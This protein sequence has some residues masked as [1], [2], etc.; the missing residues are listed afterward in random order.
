MTRAETKERNRRALL[1]AALVVIT[2]DGI[3][4]RLDDIAAQAE[5]TTGAVYSLFG[6]KNALVLA[7]VADS[8][9]PHYS[10]IEQS[11]PPGSELLEAV[12][13]IARDYRRS[14][15]APDAVAAMS[16]QIA[17][18]DMSLHDQELGAQLAESVRAQESVLVGLLTGRRH[19]GKAVTAQ[20][21][22]RLATALRALFVGL[23]QGVVLGI[24][25]DIDEQY[26]TDAARALGE[27]LIR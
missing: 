10:A 6:S 7:L 14:C 22:V 1:N 3:R 13:A 24:T 4:A 5:L 16:L 17:L 19:R 18:L 23:S 15:V 8:L 27:G 12:D 25:D 9:Q 26:F 2:R 11:V 21:A 20:Q